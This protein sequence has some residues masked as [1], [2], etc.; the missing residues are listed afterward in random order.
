MTGPPSND[1]TAFP[2][3]PYPPPLSSPRSLFHFQPRLGVVSRTLAKCATDLA[4]FLVVLSVI[5]A[6]ASI[7]A[8]LVFGGVVQEWSTIGH[9]F[10]VCFNMLVFQDNNY[11]DQ[12]RRRGSPP[13]GRRVQSHG[14]ARRALTRNCPRA[15]RSP[16]RST[17]CPRRS[18]T[19][20]RG[21]AT[22][23][24]ATVPAS[25]P[26]TDVRLRCRAQA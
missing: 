22:W 4:H 3:D 12:A 17:T 23:N 1:P 2:D 26:P 20:A 15:S 5:F 13:L 14:R 25:P 8:Y 21:A 7:I 11:M 16:R 19:Q 18:T 6:T 24:A 9:A 10:Q